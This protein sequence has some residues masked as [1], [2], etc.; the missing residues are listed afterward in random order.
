L[1]KVSSLS[2]GTL[3]EK[4]IS[5]TAAEKIPSQVT[6]TYNLSN[7]YKLK[8]A[9]MRVTIKIPNS[10]RDVLTGNASDGNAAA[11]NKPATATK[12]PSTTET[13][14][15]D[16][17]A[18]QEPVTETQAPATT[19]VQDP[20]ASGTQAGQ[21]A[22]TN[23]SVTTATPQNQETDISASQAQGAT[24]EST[25]S[26]NKDSITLYTAGQTKYQLEVVGANAGEITWKSSSPKTA[27][28]SG[29]GLVTAKKA[30]K[31][32]I[33]AVIDGQ[34]LSCA[35][36][37]KNPKVTVKKKSLTVKKGRKVKIGYTL[38]PTGQKPVF[39]S[40]NKKIAKV[41]KAGVVSGIKKGKT[42][43]TLKYGGTTVTIKVRVK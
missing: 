22:D 27:S 2:S 43:I 39:T 9:S 23:A 33:T 28:V 16:A 41:T 6:Y 31:T 42:K 14:A 20:N 17:M 19:D 30:G 35:V 40:K 1:E 26:L 29:N 36:I 24:T 18:T 10:V 11:T 38:N 21:T 3:T 4:G 15:P 25:P 8:N 37:V 13:Q 7:N 32:T 34:E 12:A 5:W